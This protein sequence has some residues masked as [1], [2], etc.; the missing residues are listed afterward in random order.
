MM[1]ERVDP[2]KGT[3]MPT[4]RHTRGDSTNEL[5]TA[6]RLEVT[7][8]TYTWWSVV[9]IIHEARWCCLRRISTGEV[10]SVEQLQPQP[11]G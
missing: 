8:T 9:L 2:T 4:W 11:R 6:D 1:L 10:I 3:T 5:V 7:P